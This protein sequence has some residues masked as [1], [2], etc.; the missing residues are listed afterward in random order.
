[1]GLTD[2]DADGTADDLAVGATA[3]GTKTAT[4]TQAQVD[5]GSVT[6]IATGTGT[7]TNGTTVTDTDTNT[8]PV[9]RTPHIDLIKSVSVDGG[10]TFFDAN[11]APGPTLLSG[12][13]VFRY[14]VKNDG[15]VTLF[16]VSVT[17]DNG[18]PGS[19]GDDFLVT[20]TGLADLDG[21]GQ[22]DDLAVGATATGTAPGAFHAGQY[23]NIAKASGT[24]SNGATVT[25]TDPA[26]FFGFQPIEFTG[27][28]QFN[29]PND[30]SK[31]QPKLQGGSFTINA[32]A[33]IYWD[34]FTSDKDLAQ[35]KLD[36]AT[37]GSDYA[38]L[39]VSI[40]KVW[41]DGAAA[42]QHGD[43]IF[44]VFVSNETNTAV[45]LANNTN[46]V[47]Y[48]IVDSAGNAALSTNKGLIDLIN[49]DPL[50]GNFNNFS[51]IENALS[52]DTVD[53]I[54]TNP[55]SLTINADKVWSSPDETGT[56]NTQPP[57]ETPKNY[58]ALGG[59][60]AVYG[61]NNSGTESLSGGDG[62]DM[63]D[64]RDGN[65]VLNGGNGNDFLFGGLGSDTLV[66]GAGNDT[67]LGSYGGDSV[68]GGT[69]ADVFIVRYGDFE[70][71]ADFSRSEGD[72][73][74][75]WSDRLETSA[76]TADGT[77]PSVS[78][79]PGTGTLFVDGQPVALLENLPA[80]FSVATDVFIT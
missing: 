63:I 3:T 56:T 45:S 50:I 64:G 74:W 51:N 54:L 16:N 20:L 8:V 80:P 1:S 30:V 67:L 34:L 73:I 77:P 15:N 25:D 26:N 7:G 12:T 70:R 28:P 6:N 62:S 22:M 14:S 35:I 78:Y 17:D 57:S 69:G 43:A 41:D 47:S 55:A 27:N 21:D 18:T 36:P 66:G 42:G 72:R 2:L 71:I 4:L 5:A 31:I 29:F 13:P 59:N 24:G 39:T 65:D 48:T 49:A 44:R 76:P 37:F 79:D 60:D 40:L 58:D 10:T 68:S 53:G 19:T 61:R 23:T 75:V 11:A 46:I 32:H 9:T 38:N 52:K 33:Y